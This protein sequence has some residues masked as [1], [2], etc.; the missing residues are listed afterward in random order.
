LFASFLG[1]GQSRDAFDYAH[2]RWRKDG[3]HVIVELVGHTS[4][5]PRLVGGIYGKASAVGQT[6]QPHDIYLQTL[7]TVE[8]DARGIRTLALRIEPE[9][10]V[11][12]SASQ[13]A[14]MDLL[15]S[16]PVTLKP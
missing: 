5:S 15:P 7:C 10:G 9:Q 6:P 11:Y 2:Q 8:E 1:A 14:R 12:I 13:I 3:G 16:G 4:Q